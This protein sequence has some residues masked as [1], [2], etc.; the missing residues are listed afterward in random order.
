VKIQRKIQ[1]VVVSPL[2]VALIAA[3]ITIP[4]AAQTAGA[5]MAGTGPGTASA[6]RLVTTTATVTAIDMNTRQVTLR[7]TDG[8]TFTVV[9]GPDVRN[10]SQVRVGDTLSMDFYDT[11]ALELKKGGTGAPASRSDLVGASRAEL[12]QRPGGAA[13]RETVIVADVVA[14]DAPGQTIS[15][16]GPQGRVVVLPV[17]DPEQFKRIAVGDQVQATYVEAVAVSMTPAAAPAT[18]TPV[19]AAWGRWMLGARVVNISPDVSS[20]VSGFDVQNQWTGEFDSTYFFTRNVAVEGSITWA[21]QDV[22]LNGQSV[23]AVKMMPVTFT[24]QYHFDPMT[25][26]GPTF[27]NFKPY[28]GGGFNYTYFYDNNLGNNVGATVNSGSWG[29]ALQ[30]GFDYQF[31]RNWYLNMDVKYL[32][33]NNDVR[34]NSVGNVNAGNLNSSLDFNPWVFGVGIRYRF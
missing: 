21:K 4:A 18:T 23:G 8:T 15:L 7:R 10:F 2:A 13:A 32:W 30:A 6:A 28:V 14:V 29:G 20:S 26:Y 33:I 12:G 1:C 25:D 9:A 5:A 16:R 24:L 22:S 31:Q 34:L 17:K 19:A 11:L 3:A 27:A